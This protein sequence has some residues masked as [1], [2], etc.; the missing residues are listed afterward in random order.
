MEDKAW[1]LYRRH[2]VRREKPGI[3]R[4]AYGQEF[5]LIA[6]L[7][8]DGIL[9]FIK[10]P[11]APEDLRPTDPVLQPYVDT[12]R[13][14]PYEEKPEQTEAWSTFLKTGSLGVFWPPGF[15]KMF[16]G[17]KLL[18]RLRGPKLVVVPTLMLMQEWQ[19]KLKAYLPWEQQR[20]VTLATYISAPKYLNTTFTLAIFDEAQSLPANTYIK[21]STLR[22]KY[23]LGL[24]ASPYREDGRQDLIFALTGYPLGLDWTR[25][26]ERGLITPPETR[27]LVCRDDKV[28]EREL[29]KLIRDAEPR[30]LIYCDWLE[31]GG[32]LAKALNVPFVSG[33]TRHGLHVISTSPISVVS[34]V[35]DVGIDITDLRTVV[36]YAYLF[37]SRRQE[38]QRF[39]RLLHSR[40]KGDYW[41]LMTLEEYAHY[42][43]R[44]FALY[45]K[46]FRLKV[47]EV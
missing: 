46:G 11:V 30:I 2:L 31:L 22:T 7:V 4:I 23:R 25:Y 18:A 39:G 36:E 3:L 21:M 20:E 5:A 15:G 27:V 16:L 24:S 26:I 44:L 13:F 32:K 9:P 38:I 37:G 19:R 43:K 40:F 17:L 29:E 41:I 33:E 47:E 28:K 6:N 42:N 45:E 14:P 1:A 8:R 10:R 35:A 34:K 12:K